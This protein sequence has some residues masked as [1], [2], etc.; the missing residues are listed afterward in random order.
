MLHSCCSCLSPSCLQFTPSLLYSFN[1]VYR[2]LCLLFLEDVDRYQ[3]IFKV[4]KDFPKCVLRV[5]IM[6]E[7]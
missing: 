3:Y 7:T 5:C 1:A 6:F 2:K 4:D